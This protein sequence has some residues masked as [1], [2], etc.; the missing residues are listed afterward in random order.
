MRFQTRFETETTRFDR[1]T[2]RFGTETRLERET[3]RFDSETPRFSRERQACFDRDT[4]RL[5]R[6]TT[7][8]DRET[9]RLGTETTRL[10]TDDE[11]RFRVA[12]VREREDGEVENEFFVSDLGFSQPDGDALSSGLETMA[13]KGFGR[14]V[15]VTFISTEIETRFQTRFETETTRFGTETR[16]ERE[17]TR[18]DSETPSFERDA[19]IS[20]RETSLLR[21]RDDE[22][23]QR[24]D[25]ARQRGGEAR[26]R[27]DEA[28]D[29]RRANESFEKL[30]S[31]SLIGNLSV[32][33]T[34]KYNL[35][36]VFLVNII[37]IWFGSCNFLSIPG[38]FVSD[39]YL[40]RFWTLLLG[41]IA[42]FLVNLPSHLFIS[43][44]HV[45]R[46]VK[47]R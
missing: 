37:N 3:T 7:R 21:E 19:E 15:A 16:L 42:S 6:D 24:Y 1:E 45:S 30:A 36:G 8:L 10:Q 44:R 18:F 5:D 34:T 41:S 43:S 35:G 17:T 14:T 4:T 40:G 33:L 27:D 39:A 11:V 38:A 25:E 29:R 23:R 31:M 26:D 32:Y 20:E 2:A 28:P 22:A 9:A 46:R 13:E 12:E 47:A